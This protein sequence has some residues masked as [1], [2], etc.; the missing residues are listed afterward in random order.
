[1]RKGETSKLH[2]AMRLQSKSTPCSPL[3]LPAD[4][5]MCKLILGYGLGTPGTVAHDLCTLQEGACM[6]SHVFAQH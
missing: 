1:M 6:C 5:L 2:I 3:K 4:L